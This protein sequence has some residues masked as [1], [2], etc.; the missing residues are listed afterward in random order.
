MKK[1][2]LALTFFMLA[3]PAICQE[4]TKVNDAAAAKMLIGAHKLS[5]QWISWDY[6][7]T[8][9]VKN[10]Q[11]IYGIKGEQR[12]RGKSSGDYLTIEG[13]I[14][15]IDKDQFVVEGDIVTRVSYIYGGKPCERHGDFTFKITGKR[16][17][18]RMQEMNNP[19]DEATDYV[20]IY[21]R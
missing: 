21:F 1:S 9:T 15:S 11:A 20:D 7:G 4:R 17:Y 18:W 2:T 13:M 8:A 12:G 6:F 19:C 5:L 3:A 10:S 14:V 16:K